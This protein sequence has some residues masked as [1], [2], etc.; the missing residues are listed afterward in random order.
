MSDE[1]HW[2]RLIADYEKLILDYEESLAK[3]GEHFG[4]WP[5]QSEGKL[6]LAALRTAHETA[7]Q[8]AALTPKETP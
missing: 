3:A 6:I 8:R 7:I 5:T 4:V 2:K 1:Q